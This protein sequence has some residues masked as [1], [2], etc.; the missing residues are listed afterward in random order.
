V[1]E[2]T[3]SQTTEGRVAYDSALEHMLR[4]YR[5]TQSKD[6]GIHSYQVFHDETLRELVKSK[7]RYPESLEDV[8][9]F[10]PKTIG[11]HGK[12]V[13]RVIDE[14]ADVRWD[15]EEQ[16]EF[17]SFDASVFEETLGNS[18]WTK[19]LSQLYLSFSQGRPRVTSKD[20]VVRSG[21]SEETVRRALV[22]M[23]EAGMILRGGR[24]EGHMLDS[25]KERIENLI[26]ALERI[27]GKGRREEIMHLIN[28][29]NVKDAKD[30]ES[31]IDAGLLNLVDGD[32]ASV[33]GYLEDPFEANIWA[34]NHLLGLLGTYQQTSDRTSQVISR[35]STGN[36]AENWRELLRPD[37]AVRLPGGELLCIEAALPL[38]AF[39]E[40]IAIPKDEKKAIAEGESYFLG[41][42]KYTIRTTCERYV[43]PDDGTANYCFLYIPSEEIFSYISSNHPDLERWAMDLHVLITGPAG[44]G[45]KNLIA[46]LEIET[47]YGELTEHYDSRRA[48]GI[49]IA[50]F[51]KKEVL[52]EKEKKI[53]ELYHK[54]SNQ[55]RE[56]E[57]AMESALAEMEER[58]KEGA[59]RKRMASQQ[60]QIIILQALV[61]LHERKKSK[62]IPR[63]ELMAEAE[64][65]GLKRS[66]S[67]F[68]Q[69]LSSLEE[70]GL[71][72]RKSLQDLELGSIGV[73]LKPKSQ[74]ERLM[75]RFWKK[76]IAELFDDEGNFHFES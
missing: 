55:E 4:A 45:T 61:E 35:F 46:L 72:G 36:D 19:I 38:T 54:I 57:I 3:E 58:F 27:E 53:S 16:G 68:S 10:G 42:L 73:T 9:R 17:L 23:E 15:S 59:S 66:N 11:A 50:E 56:I 22:E 39:R 21:C 1:N 28:H 34:A 48:P 14:W 71:I 7:P 60:S 12:Q 65:M 64:T 32:P 74:N 51:D 41:R 49:D 75:P 30:R 31:E 43:R 24:G 37:A 40:L 20:L 25:A 29:L 44:Y 63:S 62:Y 33:Q 8:H 70:D 2:A 67:R 52:G 47:I 5:R 69:I 6:R 76:R 26:L 13:L 18:S